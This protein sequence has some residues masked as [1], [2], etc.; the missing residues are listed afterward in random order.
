MTIFAAANK[1]K[2]KIVNFKSWLE[3]KPYWEQ[4]LW[5]LHLEKEILND[6]DIEKC[7]QY[8]LED[9][10]IVGQ[11]PGRVPIVFPVLD[12]D[13]PDTPRTKGTLDKIENLRHINAIDDE[14]VLELGKNLTIIYGDNGAGKSGIGRLLS[15]ACSS[16]K[17]RKLLPNARKVT[18]A[19]SYPSADFHITDTNGPRTIKYQLGQTHSVL[20]EFAVFDHEC[21]LVHLN[22]ENKVEFVPSK[23]Q[24]FDDVFRSISIIE[25]KLQKE[26]EA[27]E[28][29]NPTEDLFSGVSP[30]TSFLSDLSHETTDKEIDDVLKFKTED[31]VTLESK[32]K[33]VAK[34]LKQDVAAQK[35]SLQEEC[36]DLDIFK[37]SLLAKSATLSATKATQINIILKE[38]R[39]KKNIVDKLSAKS[40]EFKA[41]RN[42]GSP[43]WKALITAAQ[44]LHEKET[45]SADGSEPEHCLLCRRTLTGIE[46]TLFGN[47]WK[48]LKSTAQAE[49]TTARRTLVSYLE[50]LQLAEI[51]WPTFPETEVAVKILKKDASG[52]LKKLKTN[53]GTM[54]IQLLV[55][56]D[57]IKKE[58]DVG[59]EDPSI[60]LKPISKLVAEKKK[61]EER[62]VDSTSQI[63]K[64]NSEIEYFEQKQQAS[65]L[66]TKI[67]K[68]ITWLRWKNFADSM[69]LPAVRGGTTRKK[70]DIMGEIVISQYVDIFNKETKRLDCNFGLKVESHG[71]EAN[72]I[73]EL[74]LEFARGQNPSDILSEGEQTVSALADFLTEAQLD[75]NNSGI[76]FDDPVTS[77]D[78]KRSSTIALR[79]VQEA[80]ERQVIILTHDIIFLLELEYFAEKNSM[81]SHIVT[82]QKIGNTVGII[83]P[84]LSK[85]W[86]AT[87]VK[88]KV[89]YLRNELV[90]LKKIENGDPEDYRKS[91][92]VWYEYLRESWERAV[93]ERLFKGV[94]Q[95][96][97][98]A[99]Q[100]QKL[101][102][103]QITDPLL[104]EIDEGMTE[105]SSWLHDSGAGMNPGLP[106]SA[107]LDAELDKLDVFIEKVRP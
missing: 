80:S 1:E 19:S 83:D 8:L 91:V 68:H 92:K 35:K 60:D 101:K 33:E 30:I 20:K 26:I 45:V 32:K 17:P 96:F 3:V 47:Y 63:S 74:K 75:N 84:A 12:F 59:H 102:D 79:L 90:A 66:A 6:T 99:V 97:K 103:I 76:I 37:N 86:V 51:S 73:K 82:M 14:C 13:A 5:Q 34:K 43:E 46:K 10:G 23:I 87:N 2:P 16:R 40:F 9:N 11:K 38:I 52:E 98:K 67:K 18:T 24:I 41:F 105:S 81:E 85:P 39:Q 25:A 55:W 78:H 62:L 106:N 44:K 77:L 89:G 93:E 48:F 104:K 15:N 72:T 21:A 31:K 69:N 29:E 70:A 100:T 95:R 53:F 50:E 65:R 88:Q 57:K 42:I 61:I 27:K 64:L 71:R 36:H 4:Y 107:K 56:I 28:F 58:Q 54:K 7:Y 49:L 22:S 94:V